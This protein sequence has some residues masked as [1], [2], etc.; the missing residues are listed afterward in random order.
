MELVVS[1]F[2]HNME[3]TYR[4]IVYIIKSQRMSYFINSLET[5]RLASYF[6]TV[7]VCSEMN[8][9]S[10]SDITYCKEILRMFF[11]V[12]GIEPISYY[13]LNVFKVVYN[14]GRGPVPLVVL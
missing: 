13:H 3:I 4:L 10:L 7:S 5:S 6:S 1:L 9:V 8:I 12:Y 11:M 2:S 14:R